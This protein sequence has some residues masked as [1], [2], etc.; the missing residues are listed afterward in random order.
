MWDA[1]PGRRGAL[2]AAVTAGCVAAALAIPRIA[3]PLGYH[4]FADRRTVFG[5]VNFFD[6]VSNAGFLL[7]GIVGLAIVAGRRAAFEFEAERW[8]YATFFVGL[9]LTS[10]G[11][12]YYHLAPDN[13]RLFWD[14]L[15]ITVTLVGL[16]MSQVA[17]RISVR[18]ALALL[19]PGLA[20]GAASVVYW[21][22]TEQAGRGNVVPYAVVQGYTMVALVLI[23]VLYP[24]R[25]TRGSDIY[26]LA[27]WYVLAKVLEALDGAIYG[28]GHV[29]SGHTGKHV[30][31]AI[32]GVVIC[33]MLA[34]RRRRG[35]A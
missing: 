32:A 12:T 21:I 13:P 9:V 19:L 16:L 6:V 5:I 28:A 26:Y 33:A 7:V 34:R 27:G 3:Q 15:P 29:I 23:A 8:P 10:V 22:L 2:L 24:S 4:E 30:A 31:A 1:R 25:Y 11:S 20:I 35:A 17:D 14:R 18:A